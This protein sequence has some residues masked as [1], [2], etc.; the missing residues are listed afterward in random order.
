MQLQICA[1]INEANVKK[2]MKCNLFFF[3]V[4]GGM[5]SLAYSCLFLQEKRENISTQ[6]CLWSPRCSPDL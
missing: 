6:L 3:F 1:Q 5:G 2:C 4:V